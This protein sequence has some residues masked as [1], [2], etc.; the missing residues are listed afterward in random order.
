MS[1]NILLAKASLMAK[2]N[3]NRA[4]YNTPP[5]WVRQ[6]WKPAECILIYPTG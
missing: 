2:P 3:L 4:G 6:G 1:T 5:V